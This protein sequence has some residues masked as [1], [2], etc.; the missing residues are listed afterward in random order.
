MRSSTVR[1]YQAFRHYV[2]RDAAARELWLD[3]TAGRCAALAEGPPPTF[4]VKLRLN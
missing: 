2:R 3:Q 4:Y 1:G